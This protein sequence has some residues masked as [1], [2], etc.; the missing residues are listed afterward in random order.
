MINIGIIIFKTQ[1]FL[2]KALN[3]NNYSN[4]V[5]INYSKFTV[6][7]SKGDIKQVLY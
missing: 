1:Y 7:L 4:L 6:T 3:N 5:S 2:T